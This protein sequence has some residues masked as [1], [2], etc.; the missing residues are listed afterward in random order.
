M[1]CGKSPVDPDHL[2]VIGM[3]GD[4]TK[5]STKDFSCIPLCR[6]HHSER[7]HIGTKAFEKKYNKD[8]WKEAF[9]LLRRYFTEWS[10]QVL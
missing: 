6:V 4:R 8:L 9:Y 7:H 5:Q 10:L 3:G 2:E 1:I